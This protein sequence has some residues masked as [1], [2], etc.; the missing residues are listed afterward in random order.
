MPITRRVV[1]AAAA[2]MAAT[3]ALAQ[4][5][6]IGPPKQAKGPLA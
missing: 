3:P 6:R 5:C 2:A 1:L 4:Q